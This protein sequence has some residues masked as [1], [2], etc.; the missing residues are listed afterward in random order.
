MWI[1]YTFRTTQFAA[2]KQYPTTSSLFFTLGILPSIWKKAVPPICLTFFPKSKTSSVS[3][4]FICLKELVD[5][6]PSNPTWGLYPWPKF[7]LYAMIRCKIRYFQLALICIHL[8]EYVKR[9][10][11]PLSNIHA[12]TQITMSPSKGHRQYIITRYYGVFRSPKKNL[13]KPK[14]HAVRC[15]SAH[16]PFYPSKYPFFKTGFIRIFGDINPNN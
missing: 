7:H 8:Q 1:G 12:I 2:A 5:M 10:L 16:I 13:D 11:I 15:I 9:N 4:I 3:P 6:W 14:F